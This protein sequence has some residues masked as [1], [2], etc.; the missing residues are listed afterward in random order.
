MTDRQ[1]MAM[2][3]D[4]VA[5][6]ERRYQKNAAV[7]YLETGL[8]PVDEALKGGLRRGV[9]H[10]FLG[11]GHDRQLCARPTRFIAHILAQAAGP[12]V[13]VMPQGEGLALAGLRR[14]GLSAERLLCIEADPSRLAGT[15]E[16][17]L[18]S[19]HVTA[20]VADLT[21]P[22]SL[23]ASRRLTLAAEASGVTCF[24]LHRH[25][26][27]IPPSACWTRWRIGAAPSDPVRI[28]KRALLSYPEPFSL[29]LMR[30]R[31]GEALSWKIGTDHVSSSSFPLAAAMAYN[32][33]AKEAPA[34][35]PGLT[36]G[37]VRA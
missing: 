23:T 14:A 27:F 19:K 15:V 11:E 1:G 29:T 2:L 9:V 3:R 35:R 31:G 7:L 33:L 10:E 6:I 32:A 28:G 12:V 24:L 18:H 13:W 5:R 37:A 21:E 4:T 8:P 36:V 20:V 34:G 17:V 16:D 22:L 26:H 30:C 25:E